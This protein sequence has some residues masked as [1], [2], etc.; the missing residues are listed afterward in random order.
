MGVLMILYFFTYATLID[1]GLTGFLFFEIVTSI[2][3]LMAL[4]FLN[5]L[6]FALVKLMY[7]RRQPYQSILQQLSPSSIVKPADQLLQDL[8]L[9]DQNSNSN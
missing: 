2:L 7:G 9:N 8:Q 4:I 5:P 3:F 1:H 6:S